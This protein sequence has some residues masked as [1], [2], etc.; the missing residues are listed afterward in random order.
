MNSSAHS[1]LKP[2]RERPSTGFDILEALR[3]WSSPE[4]FAAMEQHYDADF[5]IPMIFPDNPNRWKEEIHAVMAEPVVRELVDKLA[6]GTLLSSAVPKNANPSGPRVALHPSLYNNDDIS[7]YRY[8]NAF[9]IGSLEYNEVE[10]FEPDQF[11]RNIRHIPDW[12]MDFLPPAASDEPMSQTPEAPVQDDNFYSLDG[13]AHVT[14]RGVE[15]TL[16]PTQ[17]GIVR[18]LH[19]SYMK[20]RPWV[21]G[22]AIRDEVGFQD[23]SLSSA[24]R[25]MRDR[26]W[27]EL[28]ISDGRGAYR[29]NL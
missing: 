11:P 14:L 23:K 24:F 3:R 4:A 20:G 1:R 21:R 10:I 16:N 28:I 25:Y 12:L 2:F 13:Y 27:R 22:E 26:N 8:A 19:M 18:V 5:D 6:Q 17:A 9:T 7:Y 15:Y 29:L